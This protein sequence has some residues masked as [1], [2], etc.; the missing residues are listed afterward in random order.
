MRLET[1]FFSYYKLLKKQTKCGIYLEQ[2]Y[3]VVLLIIRL[4]VLCTQGG[5]RPPVSL[6]VN[7][8]PFLDDNPAR[9]GI[10][11][12]RE[13][14]V[15]QPYPITPGP[16]HRAGS[17]NR[18][19]PMLGVVPGQKFKAPEENRN[20]KLLRVTGPKQRGDSKCV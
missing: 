1:A 17:V 12:T 10:K 15:S 11:N 19:G 8:K 3:T 14:M 20:Y 9:V 5:P 2:T 13:F 7:L 4:G 16:D 6:C 18:M